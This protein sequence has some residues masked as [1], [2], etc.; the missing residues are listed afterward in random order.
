[1]FSYSYDAYK[2]LTQVSVGASVLRNYVYDTNP[3][4]S[5]Y[6]GL[7]TAGRLTEIKY[8][9]ITYSGTPGGA[10]ESTTFTDMFSYH[11]VGA[12]VGKRLRVT[13]T[14]PYQ[15]QQGQ[16]LSQTGVGDLNL[17]YTYNTE[18]KPTQIVYPFDSGSGTS[19][20]YN[21]SYDAMARLAGMTTN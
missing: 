5:S 19:P 10:Q 11:Q 8:P 15:N 4:D 20:T 12:V 1:M 7:Y 3:D 21:Y 14:N 16:W 17:A 2:L 6:S 13:K 18:G 9:A